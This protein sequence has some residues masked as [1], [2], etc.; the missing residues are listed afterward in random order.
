VLCAALDAVGLS[1]YRIGLGDASLYPSLMR[2]VGVPEPARPALMTA[3]AARDF[4]GLGQELRGLE[5]SAE[6]R[7][8]LLDA[9][10][11]RGASVVLEDSA[12]ALAEAAANM[13]AVYELLEPSVAA[14]VIFDLGLVR[15]IGYYTGAVFEVYDPAAGA[16]IGGGGRYDDLLGRFGRDLP[17]VGFALGIE[18]LHVALFGEERGTGARLP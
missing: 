3:L 12:P 8:L 16:P 14:R 2:G 9:P 6:D 11:R 13:R 5:L 17:A 7:R 15:S 10:Q 1:E 18:R 4:V